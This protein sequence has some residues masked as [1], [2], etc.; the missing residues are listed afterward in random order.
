MSSASKMI[1]D[2][3]DG[4]KAWGSLE[5]FHQ[6]QDIQVFGR[7]V[8]AERRQCCTKTRKRGLGVRE[9]ALGRAMGWGVGGLM[10]SSQSCS[11]FTL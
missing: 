5:L 9:Q 6:L 4:I 3:R 1:P 10:V 7:L 2:L 11:P 8:A